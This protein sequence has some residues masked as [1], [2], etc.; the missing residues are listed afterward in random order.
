[1]PRLFPTP[2]V[3]IYISEAI[4]VGWWVDEKGLRFSYGEMEAD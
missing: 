3:C 4:G 2:D 1:M